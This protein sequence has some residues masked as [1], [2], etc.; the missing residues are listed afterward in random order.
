MDLMDSTLI[1]LSESAG[2]PAVASL[3]RAARDQLRDRGEVDYALL[4]ELIGQASGAG[5]LHDMRGKYSPTAY[6]AIIA[7]VVAELGWRTPVP[8]RPSWRQSPAPGSPDDPLTAP[9]W[10][11]TS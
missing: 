10:P 6:E 9:V 2:C 5:V 7:P 8:S 3:A 4:N 11:P 1:F